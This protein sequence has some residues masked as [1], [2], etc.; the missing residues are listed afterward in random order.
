MTL[1]ERILAARGLSA[2]SRVAFLNPKYEL[3]HN[4][5]LLPDMNKAVERLVKARKRQEHIV[6]YG[7]YDIDGLTA[8]TLLFDGLKSFGFKFVEVF[9]PNRFDEGYGLTCDAI[10]RF[11]KKGTQLIV[12]VDC[13]S[14][15][16]EEIIYANK[17]GINVVVTDHHSCPTVRVPA[18]A[19]VNPKNPKS[20]YPFVD[21]AGVGVVFKL[22]QALQ[23]KLAGLPKG[24]EK[25]L[26]DLVALGTVCDVVQLVDENR[27]YVYFGLK[28][29]SKTKRPGIKA[30]MVVA[31]VDPE[32]VDA[33]SLGFRLGPRMNAAGRLETAK[34]AID[35][36]LT[37]D[38]MFALEKA[39]YLDDLNRL[40][41]I[42]Q[43]KILKQ[44]E[45]QAEL[46]TNDPVLVVSGVDW[47]HG[48]VG[49]V[50]SKL[51]EKYKKPIFVLHEMGDESKGSARSFGDFS[52]IDAVNAARDI[53]SKGGGHKLAAGVTM[54]TKNI[55]K[56]RKRVNKFY[57]NQNLKNQE[58]LLL[59]K[60]DATADLSEITEELVKQISQL[61]PFGIG[62]PQP[63]IKCDD[64]R[65]LKVQKMGVDAQHIKLDLGS[66]NGQVM[67]FI[68]FNAPDSFFVKIDTC[69]SVW[70]QPKI[71]QWRGI[72]SVEGQLAHLEVVE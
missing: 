41:R 7:D 25:W 72:N 42:E 21:L 50:A 4:P 59:P 6:I 22:V 27:T 32:T 9:I 48:V 38:P 66:K 24:H 3:I 70:F 68:S 58:L 36:L 63:T 17:L 35:M 15:S 12:T 67:Q 69:V 29:L 45:I 26:L 71:N 23:T 14:S 43:D 55:D 57:K 65:V 1:F 56:F 37:S 28:V 60:A 44:A 5:F 61:E 64:L 40:R 33:R 62:N 16:E 30:L 49:I 34:H 53:I 2:K 51:L 54:P 39:E 10:E 20:K 11:S 47:N 46:Y 18:I 8:A 13:G 52:V 31:G 19:V